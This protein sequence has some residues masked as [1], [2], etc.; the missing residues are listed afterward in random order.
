M[1]V[2]RSIDDEIVADVAQIDR[3]DDQ[4]VNLET[5]E[6]QE[7]VEEE[8]QLA[9]S[10]KSVDA[11]RPSASPQPILSEDE[12]A[13]R[14][15][16]V[17][18]VID[19][20]EQSQDIECAH[21]TSHVEEGNEN[22]KD[23]L[24]EPEQE[25]EI[26]SHIH[27]E[28]VCASSEIV[29]E[30]IQQ[31]VS[32]TSVEASKPTASPGILDSD[33]KVEEVHITGTAHEESSLEYEKE[34]EKEEK[35]EEFKIPEAIA[36][37]LFGN[38]SD[39]VTL[40]TTEHIEDTVSGHDVHHEDEHVDSHEVDKRQIHELTVE[41]HQ[42]DALSSLSSASDL[43][44]TPVLDRS[45]ASLY[46]EEHQLSSMESQPESHQFTQKSAP[47]MVEETP[48][49][50]KQT[51]KAP[52]DEPSGPLE[53]VEE[54]FKAEI[55]VRP[56][57]VV[58]PSDI[59]LP[60]Q[61]TPTPPVVKSPVKEIPSAL[62]LDQEEDEG[63]EVEEEAFHKEVKT[64]DCAVPITPTEEDHAF[65][66][67]EPERQSEDRQLS[68]T[69]PTSSDVTGKKEESTTDGAV[70]LSRTKEAEADAFRATIDNQY[71][72]FINVETCFKDADEKS[73][74]KTPEVVEHST[75]AEDKPLAEK[76]LPSP[77]DVKEDHFVAVEEKKHEEATKSDVKSVEKAEESDEEEPVVEEVV[78]KA[79]DNKSVKAEKCEESNVKDMIKSEMKLK[80]ESEILK[81]VEDMIT[82]K[83]EIPSTHDKSVKVS[84]EP[85]VVSEHLVES[86]KALD[87]ESTPST[88]EVELSKSHE[89]FV[90]EDVKS[91]VEDV[92]ALVEEIQLPKMEVKSVESEKKEVL[93][94]EPKL[95]KPTANIDIAPV[96][97]DDVT[98]V[99]AETLD[100]K[101][102]DFK[103]SATLEKEHIS[104]VIEEVCAVKDISEKVKSPVEEM[105]E[106]VSAV[107]V[108]K[109][110]EK[111][112][113]DVED[114][115]E[116]AV[117]L[118]KVE[119][120]EQ[121]IVEEIIEKASSLEVS[122]TPE[123][124]DLVEDIVEK[125]INV[126]VDASK[127]AEKSVVEDIVE[128]VVELPKM[129]ESLVEDI[130]EKVSSVQVSKTPEKELSLV[131]ETASP[132][133]ATPKSSVSAA[134]ETEA[135]SK[136]AE[137][138]DDIVF[139]KCE[140]YG[141]T[142]KDILSTVDEPI[143]HA[144]AE[145]AVFSAEG[146]SQRSS[147]SEATPLELE[148]EISERKL[149][150]ICA[151]TI[152]QLEKDEPVD[153]TL[154]KTEVTL[155]GKSTKEEVV[156]DPTFVAPFTASSPI[157]G[158]EL[159]KELT[160]PLGL[161][162]KAEELPNKDKLEQ[163]GEFIKEIKDTSVEL[164]S[165]YETD[166]SHE[167]KATE[168]KEIIQD[169]KDV[170]VELTS[171]CETAFTHDIKTEVKEIIQDVK[172]T[173]VESKSEVESSRE[174][175][176]E[177]VKEIIQNVK[178]VSI[179]LASKLTVESSF[180][181]KTE[182]VKETIQ[183]TKDVSVELASKADVEVK[184]TVQITKDV[185]VEM[186]S[187][188]DTD[189]SHQ[190]KVEEVTEIVQEIESVTL[191]LA[192]KSETDCSFTS[193]VV[194]VKEEIQES[195]KTSVEL[196]PE[197][198]MDISHDIQ[199][200]VK[201]II[202][203][204]KK[205]TV[206]LSSKAE[207][208]HTSKSKVEEVCETT[209]EVKELQSTISTTSEKLEAKPETHMEVKTVHSEPE[210]IPQATFQLKCDPLANLPVVDLVEPS[211]TVSGELEKPKSSDLAKLEIVEKTDQLKPDAMDYATV[212]GSSSTSVTPKTPLSPN[213]ARRE[214]V[215]SKV[216]PSVQ[217]AATLES[218]AAPPTRFEDEI[219]QP[220]SLDS[221][222]VHST[223][224]ATWAATET[225]Q[226]EDE[227]V[228]SVSLT[229]TIN[230]LAAG[231]EGVNIST[232]SKLSTI[233]SSDGEAEAAQPLSLDSNWSS[234]TFDKLTADSAARH[235]P[236]ESAFSSG[237][238]SWDEREP[239]TRPYYVV[240]E[241]ISDRSATSSIISHATDDDYPTEKHDRPSLDSHLE[242]RTSSELSNK[243]ELGVL[244]VSPVPSSPFSTDRCS[245]HGDFEANKDSLS[246][247][248]TSESSDYHLETKVDDS[249]SAISSTRSDYS[250]DRSGSSIDP[251]LLQ[252]QRLEQRSLTP[253]SDISCSSDATDPIT[254]ANTITTE[255]IQ[256]GQ[257]QT[258]VE[259]KAS[260][261]AELAD[262]KLAPHNIWLKEKDTAS[263]PNPFTDQYVDDDTDHPVPVEHASSALYYPQQKQQPQ[264]LSDFESDRHSDSQ[265]SSVPVAEY[266]DEYY[267]QH[268]EF[269]EASHKSSQP[270]TDEVS[271][272]EAYL[273]ES[274][275][276]DHDQ[277]YHPYATKYSD[278]YDEADLYPTEEAINDDYRHMGDHQNG[279]AYHYYEGSEQDSMEANVVGHPP[280]QYEDQNR[281][282]R[283]PT[284]DVQHSYVAA[285]V[286]DP[287]PAVYSPT[288]RQLDVAAP[289]AAP[290]SRDE[291]VVP[292]ASPLPSPQPQQ[293]AQSTQQQ[294]EDTLA[295]WGKPLGLPAPVA[296]GVVFSSNGTNGSPLKRPTTASNNANKSAEKATNGTN[297]MMGATPFYVDLAY[298]PHHSDPQYSDVEFFKRV[299]ARHYVLSTLEPSAQVLDALLEGK[300]SWT[301]DDKDLDVTI[302]P[303]YDS[304]ALA[305]WVSANED[306]LARN[307]IDLAPSASRC[308]INLQDH[309]TSCSAYRL[310][311]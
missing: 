167:S 239:S 292:Q 240:S 217:M 126:S 268:L 4:D 101:S 98:N 289:L 156:V 20:I 213:L 254:T 305:V 218:F 44:P 128:K 127:V 283:T 155:T 71:A 140:K 31:T 275:H 147:T 280:H 119:E 36:C 19:Q 307:R 33:D 139:E 58:D 296:P 243:K 178:D 113:C 212:S 108:S 41:A 186:A 105:F 118:P 78:S 153:V 227:D 248:Q 93:P 62:V 203:D 106:K 103:E 7:P 72:G 55:V 279:N 195:K 222:E 253:R 262:P 29:E 191:Q 120:K 131:K 200:E 154:L 185:S 250:D 75:I 102:D 151:S 136:V 125:S 184:E 138:L 60:Q 133:T 202:Q 208:D 306:V 245:S 49:D 84:A 271:D 11:G 1:E 290:S 150:D 61:P 211:K 179:E 281:N 122:K 261:K 38:G 234:K 187:K 194:E 241:S 110:T 88:K 143:Q 229:P 112:K 285:D 272:Q 23:E 244:P 26:S 45:G 130:V 180:E 309:E 10:S 199:E 269:V 232:S 293:S 27:H 304:D 168:V 99:A 89:T 137:K 157:D 177:E 247:I 251:S 302:I 91:F 196:A 142:E 219:S 264:H 301:G 109:I 216:S 273:Y 74:P 69:M 164:A 100:I 24:D 231:Y 182:E 162:A 52:V 34:E 92:H 132:V 235:R 263:S 197:S 221:V 266:T 13:S 158:P 286:Y 303:T 87:I 249:H 35:K 16:Q 258:P 311:F 175:K 166:Y 207:V 25:E 135:I 115:S 230:Y 288:S 85:E 48:K 114:I 134:D 233:A 220:S 28:D 282:D 37:Q 299:R 40:D 3:S 76:K 21:P 12:M 17:D 259:M 308:T 300:Q 209:K 260:S 129:A 111:E 176:T 274:E 265:S 236:E 201:E 310:E 39:A 226:E 83:V 163:V 214:V 252:Q 297:A 174:I 161:P 73:K 169:A 145:T 206:E 90:V 277:H 198:K 188:S 159:L 30:E 270:H 94:E 14:E 79:L 15:V 276:D 278:S 238:S 107:A 291:R 51:A 18:D 298:I 146:K 124:A 225:H 68:S 64:K 193:K 204:V 255:L 160:F 117:E 66:Y 80:D 56:V 9:V 224:S 8:S 121:T 148:F 63:E 152:G 149:S 267:A 5:D 165:K 104:Q 170:S 287:E 97:K 172:V 116:K 54:E 59:I 284:R 256:P 295:S 46:D 70:S 141:K 242:P 228:G 47:H 171:K 43:E 189:F 42:D 144:T 2:G 67:S 181:A 257:Q 6:C 192:A 183:I 246:S 210:V 32:S 123:K 22:I 215:E 53:E 96:Q 86:S 77:I 81:D 205:A 173:S 237:P 294:H 190:T 57:P 95:E 50:S 65:G 82:E 223:S